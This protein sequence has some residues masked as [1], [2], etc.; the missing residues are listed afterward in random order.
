MRS[1]RIFALGCLA[2]FLIH[3]G[4]VWADY[5]PTIIA[6]MMVGVVLCGFFFVPD[7]DMWLLWAKRNEWHEGSNPDD[8][9]LVVI[10]EPIAVRVHLARLWILFLPTFAAA[11][12]LVLTTKGFLH[13]DMLELSSAAVVWGRLAAGLIW[14]LLGAWI[15]ER[16]LL[17]RADC[18]QLAGSQATA[19]GTAYYFKLGEEIYD[20]HNVSLLSYRHEPALAG[21]VF[22]RRTN[23]QRNR[24]A[25]AFIFHGFEVVAR[26][27]Q[28]LEA[29]RALGQ[30][31]ASAARALQ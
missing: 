19:S 21:A 26:G 17:W 20:G 24:M 29:A 8:V 3:E 4:I 1:A 23:P 11:A 10:H 30:A 7:R 31:Q 18:A 22:Y 14:F 5:L 12:Y 16:W 25:R 6:V 15:Y 13:A 27:I 9:D 28:D 2:L